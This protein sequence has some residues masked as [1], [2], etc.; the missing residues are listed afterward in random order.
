MKRDRSVELREAAAPPFFYGT[1]GGLVHVGRGLL[2]LTIAALAF[3]IWLGGQPALAQPVQPDGRAL[4]AFE[5]RSLRHSADVGQPGQ[6][7]SAPLAEQM[8]D[9]GAPPPLPG[10]R[11]G[12]PPTQPPERLSSAAAD[13]AARSTNCE[14]LGILFDMHAR[15]AGL[16]PLGGAT[17]PPLR[18]PVG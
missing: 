11:H 17:P 15:R 18:V 5:T 13:A 7:P 14:I 8:R 4:N 9:S 6:G 3:L 2:R 16:Y 12:G 1:H 10:A